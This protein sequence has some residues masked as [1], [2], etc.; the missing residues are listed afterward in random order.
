MTPVLAARGKNTRTA[1]VVQAQ[2]GNSN[3]KMKSKLFF[4]G[5][6][7]RAISALFDALDTTFIKPKSTICV[8]LHW[9]EKGNS[10]FV[11]PSF[12]ARIVEKIKEKGARAFLTDT[13]TLYQGQRRNGVDSII[14]AHEHGFSYG[15]VGAPVVV[16]DGILGMDTVEYSANLKHFKTVR[17]ASVLSNADGFVVISHFKGHIGLGI[18]G[19]LKNISMGFASRS[20]KQA[21]HADVKPRFVSPDRCTGCGV[22]VRNCPTSSIKIEDGKAKFDYSSCIGCGECIALCPESALK[23]IWETDAEMFQEKVAETASVVYNI[24]KGR[25]IFFNFL[26]NVMPFCDCMPKEGEPIVPD[27]G[28]LASSDPVALDWASA[29]LVNAGPG[30]DDRISAANPGIPWQAH[31]EYAEKLGIGTR[32]YEIIDLED[33]IGR[34]KRLQ[35]DRAWPSRTEIS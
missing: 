20:Q 25:V 27:I 16:G 6:D 15:T 32:S 1:A 28:I 14:L 3:R 24:I 26:L 23:I 10:Y 9:G 30:V 19:A 29:E 7:V 22:C 34:E 11:P 31:I 2:S 35:R 12:V 17:L 33:E 13:T 4:T 21:M 5:P 18:G 8:K